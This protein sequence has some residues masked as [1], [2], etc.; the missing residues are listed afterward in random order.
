L[1]ELHLIILPDILRGVPGRNRFDTA[2]R[3]V[4]C[5]FSFLFHRTHLYL[6]LCF[7]L[8]NLTN[9]IKHLNY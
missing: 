4:I 3:F 6:F 8:N 2:L 7:K 9:I 1:I 5:L